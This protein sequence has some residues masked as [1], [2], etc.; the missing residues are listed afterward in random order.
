M[1]QQGIL[2]RT[3][4][5]QKEQKS[6]EEISNG[7]MYFILRISFLFLA[8]WMFMLGVGVAHNS[9]IPT[10]PTIAFWPAMLLTSIAFVIINCLRPMR[11]PGKE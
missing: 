11:K 1:V 5:R 9:W 6:M 7:C 10:M 2:E 4:K 3:R 8:G